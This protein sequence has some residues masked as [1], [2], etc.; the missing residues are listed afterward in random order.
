M[1]KISEHLEA[2]KGEYKPWLIEGE[3]GRVDI[4]VLSYLKDIENGFFVEAGALDGL[5]MSNTKLLE[6]LGWNGILIEPSR[7]AY[8]K[9]AKNRRSL[10]INCALVSKDYPGSSVYGDFW[11]DGED[12]MGAWSG[13]NKNPYGVRA[14]AEAHART[15]SSILKEQGIKKVDFFN[16]D[17]EGY[18]LEVLKGID[19]SEVEIAYI[20]VEVNLKDYSL[21]EMDSYLGQFGYKNI[22]CLSGFTEDMKGWDGSHQDYLFRHG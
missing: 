22:G 5:F 17:V 14:V 4:K 18:E 13:I 2:H 21:E 19:F 16:L 12:G 1:S 8:E 10:V 11:F 15:L 6:D 7:K 3:Q 9:C 20:L